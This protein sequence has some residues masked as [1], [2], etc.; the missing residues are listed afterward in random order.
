[1][2]H[3]THTTS[4][5]FPAPPDAVYDAI[6]RQG[7]WPAADPTALYAIL[8]HT[9]VWGTP[10][11]AGYQIVFRMNWGLVDLEMT[12]IILHAKRPSMIRVSQRPQ[13]FLPYNPVQRLPP[14]GDSAPA[15]LEKAFTSRFGPSPLT[16]ELQY[17]LTPTPTG[18]ALHASLDLR[19]M[20]KPGWLQR[21]RWPKQ[22]AAEAEI[23]LSR[24]T[25]GLG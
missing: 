13:R 7:H 4:R 8:S 23:A 21:R 10:G 20:K 3:L 19:M 6:L 22:A 17:D 1:M 18:T 15:N 2:H 11:T 12:E 24:I 9:P 14:I 16:V 25:A 5:D